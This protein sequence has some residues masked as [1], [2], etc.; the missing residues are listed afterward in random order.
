M[1]TLTSDQIMKATDDLVAAFAATDTSSY[2][3]CFSPAATFVFHAEPIRLN[4][5]AAYEALWATW[6]D[7]VRRVVSCTNTS[8]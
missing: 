5:R 6:L 4:D 3:A 8:L 7:D 2:F 1:S